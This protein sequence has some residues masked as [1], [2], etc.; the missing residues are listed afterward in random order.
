MCNPDE[1]WKARSDGYY[2]DIYDDERSSYLSAPIAL[3]PAEFSLLQEIFSRTEDA[4]ARINVN[5]PPSR[6]SK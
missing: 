4:K 3:T 6:W 5:D 2:I 1:P